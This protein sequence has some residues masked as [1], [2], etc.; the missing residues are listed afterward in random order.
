MYKT[1]VKDSQDFWGKVASENGW[2]MNGRGCTIW[3]NKDNEV[4]DS[5]YNK[6]DN[7]ESYI[8]QVDV[9]YEGF[10]ENEVLIKT[11]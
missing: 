11:I 5:I 3:I 4:L 2:S 7:K 6:E 8:V 9:D 1:M 10:Y